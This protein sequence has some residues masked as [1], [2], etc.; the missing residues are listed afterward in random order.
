MDSVFI[1]TGMGPNGTFNTMVDD[2]DRGLRTTEV[3]SD[4]A[5]QI[6]I[7]AQTMVQTTPVIKS[8]SVATINALSM[9]LRQ[10][11]VTKTETDTFVAQYFDTYFSVAI[12]VLQGVVGFVLVSCLLVI[13]GSLSTHFY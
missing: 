5:Y 8:N 10:L 3:K 13:I 6:E 12:Y 1:K 9:Y 2:I 11:D 4:Q 7:A